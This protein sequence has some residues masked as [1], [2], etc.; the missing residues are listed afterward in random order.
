MHGGVVNFPNPRHNCTAV[1]Q[2]NS[3][4]LEPHLEMT[5]LKYNKFIIGTSYRSLLVIF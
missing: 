1:I 5:A 2:V 4:S 3:L